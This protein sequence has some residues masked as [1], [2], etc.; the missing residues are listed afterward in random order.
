MKEYLLRLTTDE[1]RIVVE[2]LKNNLSSIIWTIIKKAYK[3]NDFIKLKEKKDA[4]P[5]TP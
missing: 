4:S 3:R 5:K 1:E 2:S